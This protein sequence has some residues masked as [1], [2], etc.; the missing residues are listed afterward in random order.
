MASIGL[1]HKSEGVSVV[2]GAG[3]LKR[4][5]VL[6]QSAHTLSVA[7]LLIMLL[8]EPMSIQYPDLS[9]AR[10]VRSFLVWSLSE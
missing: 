5:G 10:V 4:C 7:S 2:G 8:Y 1:L 3:K 6:P 9:S